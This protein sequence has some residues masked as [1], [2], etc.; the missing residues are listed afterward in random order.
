MYLKAEMIAAAG[1]LDVGCERKRVKDDFK[2][3]VLAT[4]KMELTFPE[5]WINAGVQVWGGGER[6]GLGMCLRC[7]WDGQ[8]EGK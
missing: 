6:F 4:A 5:M 7:Q 3:W 8:V 1:R 2:I